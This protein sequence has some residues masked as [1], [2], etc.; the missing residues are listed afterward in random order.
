MDP[1]E[2]RETKGL[3]SG[4]ISSPTPS[5]SNWQEIEISFPSFSV[6]DDVVLS[7]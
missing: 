2:D 5:N 6:L 1:P 3:S 7:I 4:T